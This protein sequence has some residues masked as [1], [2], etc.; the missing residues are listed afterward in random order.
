MKRC[1]FAVLLGLAVL[2][3]SSNAQA[4]SC[5]CGTTWCYLDITTLG[6]PLTIDD[7]KTRTWN[8]EE[9]VAT[10]SMSNGSC[11]SPGSVAPKKKCSVNGSTATVY[12]WK[13]EGSLN[14][15]YFGVS[16]QASKQ[17]TK[18]FGSG[19][20]AEIASWCS[21]C[22]T[23]GFVTYKHTYK[24]GLCWCLVFPP[25]PFDCILGSK[26]SGTN[27]EFVSLN[28]DDQPQCVVP[29]NCNPNCPPS[30]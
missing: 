16:G 7:S 3:G 27:K 28:C 29:T 30:E 23:R 5:W 20:E 26:Y 10:S 19:C 21:C 6:D 1:S 11:P 2:F 14:F 12:D 17:V 8:T 15:S 25:T 18:T 22:Y 4:T 9:T 24:E 13:V